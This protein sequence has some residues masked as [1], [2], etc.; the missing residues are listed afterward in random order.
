MPITDK[1]KYIL[2]D[3]TQFSKTLDSVQTTEDRWLY[4][5]KHAGRADDLPDFGD[6]V[7]SQAIKRILVEKA[8]DRLIKEQAR[9]M[10]FTEE[11]LDH[12]AAMKVRIRKEARA[13]GHSD[14][15]ADAITALQAMNL[16]PEQISEFKEKLAALGK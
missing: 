15:I 12:L 7:I 5:L 1:V 9:D 10:V 11:E 6:E 13:E 2:Y 3:L 8:S 4:L 16:S 14:A